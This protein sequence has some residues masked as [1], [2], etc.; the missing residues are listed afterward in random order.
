VNTNNSEVL[1]KNIAVNREITTNFVVI[2]SV[3]SPSVSLCIPTNGIIR[4][5]FPVLDSIYDQNIDENSFEVVV[6]DNGSSNE[7]RLLM[8]DYAK[9]HHNLTYAKTSAYEFLSEIETYKAAKGDFIK[10]I[11]HRTK[12]LPGTLNEFIHFSMDHRD[13]KPT[14]YF[15]NGELKGNKDVTVL[16]TFDQYVKKLSYFSS[17]S[18]G[19]GFWK[20]QFETLDLSHPNY[21]FPHTD[22]LFSDPSNRTYIVDNRVLLYEMP[23]GTVP[24]GTYNLFYAFTVEYLSIILNLCRNGYI[25]VDTFNTVKN[26][27]LDFVAELYLTYVVNKSECSYDL[28]NYKKWV[29]CYYSLGQLKSRASKIKMQHILNRFKKK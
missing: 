15:S 16:E 2:S 20:S 13:K 11:N 18:T 24:K 6:M 10:F 26:D 5:V 1:Y 4:W 14:V 21:L 19:M 3:K 27:N 9:K 8:T 12:L 23:T 25:S 28:S 22:I 7:F 29:E 17:W